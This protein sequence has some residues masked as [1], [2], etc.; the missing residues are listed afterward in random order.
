VRVCACGTMCVRVSKVAQCPC[1]LVVWNLHFTP[2]RMRAGVT[3]C[4]WILG[5]ARVKCMCVQV[6]TYVNRRSSVKV[7]HSFQSV[8]PHSVYIWKKTR[9]KI[10]DGKKYTKNTQYLCL[11]WISK[12][13]LGT[14]TSQVSF[15][16]RAHFWKGSFAKEPRFFCSVE[17]ENSFENVWPRMANFL[18]SCQMYLTPIKSVKHSPFGQFT[19]KTF[20]FRSL[21]FYSASTL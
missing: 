9:K 4:V 15:C 12:W 11:L 14:Q 16:K 18:C 13:W 7:E 1:V 8:W 6:C 2:A 17:V 10:H 21:H 3:I 5:L 20:T 19:F